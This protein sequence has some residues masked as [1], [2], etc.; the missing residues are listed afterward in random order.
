MTRVDQKMINT[1][2]HSSA[3][4][5]MHRHST[6]RSCTLMI[7]HPRDDLSNAMKLSTRRNMSLPSSPTAL[8]SSS[9]PPLFPPSFDTLIHKLKTGMLC[10]MLVASTCRGKFISVVEREREM[11]KRKEMYPHH[12]HITSHNP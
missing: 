11:K 9:A 7:H 3:L 6:N 5:C 12:I 8:A 4:C 2:A 10:L 1:I